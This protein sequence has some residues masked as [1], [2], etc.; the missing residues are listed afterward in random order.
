MLCHLAYTGKCNK[1][2]L[3]PPIYRGITLSEFA[4][5]LTI[6]SE[7]FSPPKV[8]IDSMSDIVAAVSLL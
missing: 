7:A 4:E 8:S 2:F 6:A 3:S 5:I 1:I